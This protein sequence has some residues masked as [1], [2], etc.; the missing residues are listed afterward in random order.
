MKYDKFKTFY[1]QTIVQSN[2]TFAVAKRVLK[3]TKITNE[4]QQLRRATLKFLTYENMKKRLGYIMTVLVNH[5]QIMILRIAN[6]CCTGRKK[7][8]QQWILSNRLN[9]G[10][11]SNWE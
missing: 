1:C 7:I 5:L 10:T 4:K 9:K 8:C 3:N 11:R 2:Q 6:I